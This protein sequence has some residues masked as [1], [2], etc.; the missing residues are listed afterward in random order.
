MREPHTARPGHDFGSGLVEDAIADRVA[1]R[2]FPGPPIEQRHAGREPGGVDAELPCGNRMEHAPGIDHAELDVG[3]TER[4]LG[5]VRHVDAVPRHGLLL[6]VEI[7]HADAHVVAP[8]RHVERALLDDAHARRHR[9]P[10]L[11]NE[12]RPLPR[13]A[14]LRRLVLRLEDHGELR[15]RGES[16]RALEPLQLAVGNGDRH[17]QRR[18]AVGMQRDH[19]VGAETRRVFGAQRRNVGRAR[20]RSDRPQ[21]RRKSGDQRG[22]A[23]VV[24][25]ASVQHLERTLS[26]PQRAG[27]N[28]AAGNRWGGARR[29]ARLVMPL[30]GLAGPDH[31]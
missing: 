19:D 10:E 13:I 12:Q 18:A 27:R 14:D 29:G 31:A 6:R 11:G 2:P 26:Q 8:R 3:E 4:H 28:A 23:E 5:V 16:L 17:A 7:A 30:T 1:A 9:V 24:K 21:D 22:R 20:G 25:S 15:R